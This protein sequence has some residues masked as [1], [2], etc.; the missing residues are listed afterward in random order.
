MTKQIISQEIDK[1]SRICVEIVTIGPPQKMITVTYCK[2]KQKSR[3]KNHYW[4][5]GL[6]TEQSE[7]EGKSNRSGARDV[8]RS[9]PGV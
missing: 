2:N 6:P 1:S 3:Q 7:L 5:T 8:S 4:L 9:D